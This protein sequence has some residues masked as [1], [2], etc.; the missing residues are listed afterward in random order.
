MAKAVIMPK[1]GFTQEESTIV[2]WLKQEGDFVERGDPIAEVTTDKIN[3]EIEAPETGYLRGIRFQAGEEVPVTE[4]IAYILQ[5]G[6]SIPTGEPAPAE[7]APAAAA[8]A[9]AEAVPSPAGGQV[10]AAVTPV[11]R[12]MAEAE[13]I[14]LTQVEGTGPGGKITREDVE[15]YLAG[16]GAEPATPGAVRATPAARRVAREHDLDL[17]AIPGSGPRGRVQEADALAAAQAAAAPA[18]LPAPA[19]AAVTAPR[20]APAAP[21][22]PVVIPMEGMRRTIAERLQA[23][24]QEAPHVTFTLD[25][26]MTAAIALREAANKRLAEGQPRVSMTAVLIKACAWALRQHPTVNAYLIKDQIMLMPDVN[27]GMAV[28]LD[29]GLIVPVIRS[30]DRKGLLEIGAEVADL[31]ARAR[32]GR[33]HPT[34]VMDG[35]FT[36][37]NLGMYG[38]DRFTA[39]I[40]PPQV[41]IL[42][43]GRTAKRF[44]P[45]END[46]PV[47]RPMMTVTLVVD[48]RVID[49]AVAAQFVSTLRDALEDPSTLLF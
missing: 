19:P 30:A 23:S 25:I 12:R 21:G 40:N 26:D 11:A 22:E 44:V 15:A 48:H 41:A 8:P 13:G 29:A 5:E 31:T 39:I 7:E 45:D 32:E 17:A 33:L 27:V 24:Y 4:V 20:P 34:D 43:V 28:A 10:I 46:Q 6:E 38:I 47:A 36:V 35:T 1:F 9:P 14:D 3:M 42:A 16:R 2:A 18:P 37:S 49:G